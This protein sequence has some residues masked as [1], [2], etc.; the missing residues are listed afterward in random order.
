MDIDMDINI[1]WVFKDYG[2]INKN[3]C[4]LMMSAKVATL[5]L[6]TIKVFWNRGYDVII[7]GL[8]SPTKF[9]YLIKTI[10]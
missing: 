7:S 8:T 10:L 2:C 4:I 9:Y 3:G 1:F 5:G 6:L